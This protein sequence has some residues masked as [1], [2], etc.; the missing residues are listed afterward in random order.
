[1][2]NTSNDSIFVSLGFIS[3]TT[4][5]VIFVETFPQCLSPPP[6]GYL[7]YFK[8]DFHA[9]KSHLPSINQVVIWA[10]LSLKY[11]C[12]LITLFPYCLVLLNGYT[13]S[14]ETSWLFL[15]IKNKHDTVAWGSV[16]TDCFVDYLVARI[17]VDWTNVN[18]IVGICSRCSLEATFKVSSKSGQ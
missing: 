17:N 12:P 2:L 1:M 8:L 5:W 11:T 7:R 10:N 14:F 9:V 6:F 18:L 13:Y 16:R 3:I 15:I 4:E